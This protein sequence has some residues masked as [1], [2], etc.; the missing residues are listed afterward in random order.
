MNAQPHVHAVEVT[1]WISDPKSFDIKYGD[2]RAD[3]IHL[4]APDW[5]IRLVVQGKI[6][7]LIRRHDRQSLLAAVGQDNTSQIVRPF[8]L[9]EG[10]W[11]SEQLDD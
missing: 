1:P 11:G 3:Y 8:V 5:W 7:R 9:K 4:I 10:R 6:A 2:Q